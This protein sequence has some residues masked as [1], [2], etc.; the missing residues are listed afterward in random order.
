METEG[1]T[2]EQEVKPVTLADLLGFVVD[3]FNVENN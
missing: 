1:S 2:D 3:Y